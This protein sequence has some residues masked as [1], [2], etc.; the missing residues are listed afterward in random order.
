MAGKTSKQKKIP[1]AQ[2][3]VQCHIS[4]TGSAPTL[5]LLYAECFCKT[6]LGLL[7]GFAHEEP[8]HS[9]DG[10]LGTHGHTTPACSHA[11]STRL[12]R[13]EALSPLTMELLMP[14]STSPTSQKDLSYFILGWPNLRARK[15]TGAWEG[16]AFF[17]PFSFSLAL[18]LEEQTLCFVDLK[19]SRRLFMFC[20]KIS[21]SWRSCLS[22]EMK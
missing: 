11:A 6:K 7:Q 12:R 21:L 18:L 22:G 19:V 4:E 8:P 15:R 17:L 3:E 20:R 16:L 1:K 13:D 9:T 2:F 14:C 10:M 5:R